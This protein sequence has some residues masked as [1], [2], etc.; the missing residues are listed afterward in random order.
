MRQIDRDIRNIQRAE[1]K[2]KKRIKEIAKRGNPKLLMPMAKE[3]VASRKARERLMTSKF[4]M[5][6]VSMQI[7]EQKA[8]LKMSKVMKMSTGAM[9]S[10]NALMNMPQMQKVIQQMSM[11][12]AK[13]GFIEEQVAD[14]MGSMEAD[15]LE[16]KAE[17]EVNQVMMDICGE[18]WANVG[19]V[20]NPNAAK[21][22]LKQPEVAAPAAVD[23]QAED[24]LAMRL[25]AL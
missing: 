25:E 22:S 15:D 6:S 12:M 14:A 2:V 13:A 8:M 17:E 18:Q 19:F 23:T 7:K 10:M 3:L 11:E 1:D 20:A 16:E 4:H 24:A 5:K 21:Q 9:K